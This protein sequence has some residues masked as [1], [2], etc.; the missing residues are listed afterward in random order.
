MNLVNVRQNVPPVYNEI[1]LVFDPTEGDELTQ[2]FK[3]QVK[4]ESFTKSWEESFLENVYYYA[5][6]Y[7]DGSDLEW[8]LVNKSQ[9]NEDMFERN[10]GPLYFTDHF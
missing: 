4:V 5:Y 2:I 1:E 3:I 9:M 10:L 8:K 6:N 7:Q